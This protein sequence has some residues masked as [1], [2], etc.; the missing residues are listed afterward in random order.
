MDK[1]TVEEAAGHYILNEM[2]NFESLEIAAQDGFI[3]GAAWQR[4]QGI[5]WISV[6]DENRKPELSVLYLVFDPSDVLTHYTA[7][8]M[9]LPTTEKVGCFTK[10]MEPCFYV[11]HYAILNLPKTDK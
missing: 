7:F 8:Y 1:Q 3:D 4:E 9:P 11:T 10:G 6:S 5:D 2:Y